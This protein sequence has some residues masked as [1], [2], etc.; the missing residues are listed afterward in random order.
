[1]WDVPQDTALA[2]AI[3]LHLT[4][5]LPPI[6]IAAVVLPREGMGSLAALRERR[7]QAEERAKEAA[8]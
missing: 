3:V 1:L 6:L 7:R 2:Y 8:S 5:F 4:L